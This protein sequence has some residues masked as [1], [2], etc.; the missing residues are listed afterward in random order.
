MSL[1]LYNNSKSRQGNWYYQC[2]SVY[3]GDKRFNGS[4]KSNKKRNVGEVKEINKAVI[5]ED[6]EKIEAGKAGK[7]RR[8]KEASHEKQNI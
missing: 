4:R 5:T 3:T 1:K 6:N 8:Q 2:E 7:Q